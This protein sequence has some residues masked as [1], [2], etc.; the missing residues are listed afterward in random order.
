MAPAAVTRQ[1]HETI[2]SMS[3]P[4][5]IPAWLFIHLSYVCF[6]C[7]RPVPKEE[8]LLFSVVVAADS[9]HDACKT[10]FSLLV[11]SFCSI[12]L[13]IISLPV[14]FSADVISAIYTL[15]PVLLLRQLIPSPTDLPELNARSGGVRCNSTTAWR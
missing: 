10:S 13:Y 5:E 4:C 1:G 15:N 7:I 12:H 14:L 6:V 11:Q 9:K 3:F 8:S 2:Y